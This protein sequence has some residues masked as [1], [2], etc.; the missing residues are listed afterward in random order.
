MLDRLPVVGYRFCMA[1]ALGVLA[2]ACESNSGDDDAEGG[3]AGTAQAGGSAGSGGSGNAGAG[4]SG[5]AAGVGGG[6][7]SGG[8]GGGGSGG[9][10]GSGG[11]GNAAGAGG[12][13]NA[14]GV[15]GSASGGAGASAGTGGGAAGM[16]VGGAGDPCDTAL[17]CDDFESYDTAPNGKWT[18]RVNTGAVAIDTTQHVSGTKS[19]KI[20]SQAASYASAMIRIQD[21]SIF[22]LEGNLL[23]GRMMFWLEA[24]PTTS[25][26]WTFIRGLGTVPG[27]T[28]H[29][30][31]R[32]GGQQ[33][34]LDG[35]MF[36]G[37][38]LMANYET[39]DWYEDKATPGSDCWHHANGRVIPALV[40]TCV[41]WKFD[42]TTNGMQLWLDGAAADD[43]TVDG[44]G[45]GCVN[46]PADFTW[47]APSFSQLD[48]GW[49]SYQTD[50]A[51]T[52]YIDDVVLS[53]TKIGCP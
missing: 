20:T 33:P 4:G 46:A 22:P 23:Y 32:Y 34:I 21:P 14:A 2:G 8:A 26:H 53:S 3:R 29:A 35:G 7:G 18:V 13:G 11:S 10:G 50:T 42:G 47:T 45:Q 16:G 28:H 49:E 37:N 24:A 19:V 30:E 40:W 9:A 36:V 1:V 31:Y 25:V 5:N 41:E 6:S 39:P 27:A 38:Q 43:L 51:R 12:S 52:A 44:K 48:L 17:Y 15:G